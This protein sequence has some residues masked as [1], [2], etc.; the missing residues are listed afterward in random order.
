M[1]VIPSPVYIFYVLYIMASERSLGT[2]KYFSPVQVTPLSMVIV[3]RCSP[4]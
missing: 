2:Y 3:P 4:D 1:Y